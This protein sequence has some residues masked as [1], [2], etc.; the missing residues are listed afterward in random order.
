MHV[1]QT[2]ARNATDVRRLFANKSRVSKVW[3]RPMANTNSTTQN[4]Q[5]INSALDTPR[6]QIRNIMTRHKNIEFTKDYLSVEAYFQKLQH[7]RFVI[8]PAGNGLDCHAHWEALLAGCIPIIP[9]SYLDSLFDN[10]PV[11]LLSDWNEIT[12][13]SIIEKSKF[14]SDKDNWIFEKCF[15]DW[16]KDHINL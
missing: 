2:V 8:S 15:A 12:D 16:W 1:Y 10:L 14:F 13:E 3:I 6:D 7:Y 11:W 4:Y 5:K 9:H